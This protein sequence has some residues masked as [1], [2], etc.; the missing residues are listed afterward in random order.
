[1]TETKAFSGVKAH[2]FQ[3][4]Q[5]NNKNKLDAGFVFELLHR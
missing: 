5:S 3:K 2:V 1:M 4:Q